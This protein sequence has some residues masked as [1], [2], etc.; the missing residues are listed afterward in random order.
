MIGNDESYLR[1]ESDFLKERG[2]YVYTSTTPEY[3]DTLIS[4]TDP[5]LVFFNY[6]HP[7]SQDMELLL[8]LQQ[9]LDDQHKPVVFTLSEDAAYLV[10]SNPTGKHARRTYVTSNIVDAIKQAL[11][12]S[13]AYPISAT[14][15]GV[16]VVCTSWSA[17]A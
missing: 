9:L 10:R 5:A 15:L 13:A 17:S 12:T 2:I 11:V 1:T 16:N 14:F 4:E 6:Q 8:K 7:A 3:L